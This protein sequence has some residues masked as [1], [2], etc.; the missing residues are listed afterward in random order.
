VPLQAK[1]QRV[2]SQVEV[3]LA[4]AEQ[5][6]HDVPRVC[7]ETLGAQTPPQRCVSAV[8]RQAYDAMSQ[9]PGCG[10]CASAAHPALHWPLARSQ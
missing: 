6:E 3:P 7:V 9:L 1:S 2:P 4:G 8:H 10:H 5:G